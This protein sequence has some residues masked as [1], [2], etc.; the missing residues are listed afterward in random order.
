MKPCRK[1][2]RQIV[3]LAAAALDDGE[4]RRLTAHLE[5]CPGCRTYLAEVSRVTERL[6][7]GMANSEIQTSDRFQRELAARLQLAPRRSFGEIL[8]D[9]FRAAPLNW[10]VALPLTAALALAV[11]TFV[12]WWQ[13]AKVTV[14][15]RV[16]VQAASSSPAD[17]DLAPTIGNYQMVASQ[18]LDKLDDLLTRQGRRN[19][20]PVPPL[21]VSALLGANSAE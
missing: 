4:A 3:W 14:P 2:E 21:S 16:Q 17:A 18:S 9:C 7:A 13:P 1:Y 11:V 20:P 12:H 19:L 6:T 10:R 8:V 5:T 15:P